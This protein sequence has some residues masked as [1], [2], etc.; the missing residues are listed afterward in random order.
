M[1]Q[2]ISKN[3]WCPQPPPPPTHHLLCMNFFLTRL[4]ETK[5]RSPTTFSALY[6][7]IFPTE[8][9]DSPPPPPKFLSISC[10]FHTRSFGNTKVPSNENF[11]YRETKIR[12]NRDTLL[13]ILS[14]PLFFL[15]MEFFIF[16]FFQNAEGSPYDFFQHCE[17]KKF[18]R[19]NVKP[20]LIAIYHFSL[21]ELF[22]NTRVLPAEVFGA[23][24]Q[25]KIRP[26]CDAPL[27]SMKIFIRRHSFEYRRVTL[28]F[29]SGTVRQKAFDEKTLYPPSYPCSNL[30]TRTFLK[31]KGPPYECFRT[32]RQKVF[33]KKTWHHLLNHSFFSRP[34]RFWNTTVHPPKIFENVRPRN[35]KKPWCPHPP[36]YA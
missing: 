5:K 2:K 22:W 29:F 35:S 31:H 34:E 28:R 25:K 18:R 14:P 30:A 6:D 27:I 10:F 7:K 17:T 33:D 15:C 16:R 1:G 26:N 36:S 24:R 19:K 32:V 3:P 12:K 20:S 13:P 9:R 8:K 11:W 23:V 4:F 21:P